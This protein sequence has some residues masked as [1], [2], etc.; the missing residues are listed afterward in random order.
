VP[1]N[2]KCALFLAEDTADV[3]G[4][5]MATVSEIIEALGGAT[6]IARAIDV[7]V[8]TAHSWKRANYVP[9]WRVPALLTL[10][11]KLGKP[12]TAASFPVERSRPA[13]TSAA[14]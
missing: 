11:K 10:A 7:P 8:T 13:Q 5:R 6:A 3:Y 12:I 2:T 4:F 1:S 9:A 14:A